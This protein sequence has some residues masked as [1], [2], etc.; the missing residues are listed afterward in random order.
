MAYRD[1][2]GLTI[3]LIEADEELRERIAATLTRSGYRVMTEAD[4]RAAIEDARE[5]SPDLLLVDLDIP[6]DY[7]LVAARFILRRA[8]LPRLPVVVVAPDGDE[9]KPTRG[10]SVFRNEFVTP[11]AELGA[12]NELIEQLLPLIPDAA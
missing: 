7:E 10:E 12:V 11:A 5:V 4:S 1:P 3:M 6:V 9:D 2:D 8:G